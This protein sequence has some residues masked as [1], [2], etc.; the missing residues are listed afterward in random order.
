M[1]KACF[2]LAFAS[3]AVFGQ[4]SSNFSISSSVCMEESVVITNNSTGATTYN[5]DFC[6]GDFI[7]EPAYV[8][9][10]GLTSRAFGYALI[11]DGG[12]WYGFY[13]HR[14]DGT[15]YRVDY[16]TDIDNPQSVTS[17]GN[18][19]GVLNTPTGVD[20]IN[21]EGNWYLIFGNN[22]GGLS[23]IDFGTDITN[24]TP[25][26]TYLGNFGGGAFNDAKIILEGGDLFVI[27]PY[28]S[29]PSLFR[30]R[31]G[32]SFY[33]TPLAGDIKIDAIAGS[34]LPIGCDVLKIGNDWKAF[35]VSYISNNLIQINLGTDLFG[36]DFNIEKDDTFPE[37][38]APIKVKIAQEGSNY[39]AVV[40]NETTSHRVLDLKTT[41]MSDVTEL[42]SYV[43]TPQVLTGFDIVKY[44]A[45][46]KVHAG[47]FSSTQ[48]RMLTFDADCGASLSYSEE[49]VPT[50]L[51]YST[52]GAKEVELR[53]FDASGELSV[54]S[55]G[56]TVLNQTAPSISFTTDNACISVSNTFTPSLT[57]LT[58]YSWDF[59]GDGMED[60]DLEA[61]EVSFDTLSG[62]GTYTVRLD[63]FDGTCNNFTE[64][65]IT[66]YTD[67]PTPTFTAPANECKN[68]PI[69]F[70]NTTDESQHMGVITYEW[71]FNGEGM[72]ND[73]DPSYSFTTPGTKAITLKSIIPGCE[74]TSSVFNID[75]ADG[76]TSAFSAS[77]FS[78]CEGESISFTD[79]STNNPVSWFWDFDD[80]FTSTAQNPDHLFATA[81]NFD[82]SLTVTDA[83]GCQNTLIQEVA[84]SALPTVSFDFD[85]PC[86]S[87]DGI[88]FMDLSSVS[89][90]SIV[91]RTWYVGE[92]LLEEAQDQQNP[93]ITFAS[94]GTVNIRLETVSSTGC[95]SS[96]SEDILVRSA[97]QPEF[98][99]DIGC[100]GELST[101]TDLSVSPGN[102]IDSWFWTLDGTNYSTQDINHTFS[103]PGMF[104]VILEVSGQNFCSET[105][106]K[107]IEVLETLS[108]DLA[109]DG[110]CSNEIIAFS[111]ESVE[112]LDP[113]VSREWFLDGTLVGNGS[114]LVL[115]SLPESTYEV[116][117]QVTT[118]AGC[119]ASDMENIVVNEAP[120]SSISAP[121][122]FGV[123]GDQITFSNESNGGSSYHWLFN[124]DSISTNTE[125]TFSFPEAG[126]YLVSMVADNDLGCSDTTSVTVFIAVPNVDI[127]V[128]QFEI[129]ENDNVGTIFLEIENNSNLPI[130]NT[131]VVIEL[132]NTFS[133]TEQV[134]TLIDVGQTVL[135]S[136][137]IGVPLNVNELSYLCVFLNSQYKGFE[138]NNPLDNE[139]CITVQPKIIVEAP[140][141]NPV[142]DQVRVRLV[143]PTEG[144]ATI[145]LLNAAGKVE[146]K[147][148]PTTNEGLNNFFLDLKGLQT[149]VY[150][151]R[152]EVEG[153]IS[154]QRIV[155]L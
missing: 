29:G 23:L 43:A 64:Q 140:F 16:G 22:G 103:G 104:E 128:G 136:L 28:L 148:S 143:T 123:P 48:L 18:P 45:S 36:T 27:A 50:S 78:I 141:P 6:L 108:V 55:E 59:D 32:D 54:S 98:S 10:T 94:E 137:N 100:Q 49:V 33:N 109:V 51:S 66:I 24:A 72:S 39:F 144:T 82:V 62:P 56:L 61:P 11:E 42:I 95:S 146:L 40:A 2:I 88:Q 134:S 87:A 116:M 76:P 38:L 147:R 99:M 70:T 31:F 96:H 130:D 12:N 53:A 142:S 125:E 44:E 111:D 77:T 26:G 7:S 120:Q 46:Y 114:E 90:A 19:N 58:S 112:L 118:A 13:A 145:T 17:L 122:T 52:T 60:S 102:P 47:H 3:T 154:V 14:E 34:S 67:P 74:N 129:V 135:V 151:I 21:F 132:E 126:S 127:S 30:I 8:S 73:R 63:I 152:L 89:G 119:V 71:D 139:K 1:Q 68:T 5:W 35:V 92:S 79:Q 155:K 81:G 115:E 121:K 113:V 105:I 83:L 80:G 133:V 91:S 65:D 75:I 101:F 150:F 85:L 20:W 41:A 86:T 97:P 124:G 117:L 107:N 93:V 138:D 149:G 15:L 25:T 84:I 57:G 131:E 4:P 69:T 106:T 110:D 37:I 153:N 9:Q